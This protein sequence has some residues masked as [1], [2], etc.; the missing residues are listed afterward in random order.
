M[1]MIRMVRASTAALF[2]TACQNHS[3]CLTL[4]CTPAYFCMIPEEELLTHK[5]QALTSTLSNLGAGRP[6]GDDRELNDDDDANLNAEMV[7]RLHFGGY[8]SCHVECDRAGCALTLCTSLPLYPQFRVVLGGG[9][10]SDGHYGPG[11]RKS[12]KEIMDEIIAKSKARK[13]EKS[14]GK[15]EQV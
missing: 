14:R 6:L 4:S 2:A 5:G 8:F 1:I 10:P 9:A 7:D 15:D 3:A 13:A 11:D 12:R